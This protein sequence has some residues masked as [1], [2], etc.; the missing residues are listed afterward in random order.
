MITRM[1]YSVGMI[2]Y[3]SPPTEA[4]RVAERYRTA[5]PIPIISG[6]SGGSSAS[7]EASAI[8]VIRAKRSSRRRRMPAT[9]TAITPIAPT[10]VARVQ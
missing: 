4:S 8:A 7:C 6:G 3:R 5:M 10:T 2:S 9:T 1:P